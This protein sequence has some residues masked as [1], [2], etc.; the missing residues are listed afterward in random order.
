MRYLKFGIIF[1]I[2]LLSVSGQ[3]QNMQALSS[4][5]RTMQIQK[6]GEK[7]NVP[8]I[9]LGSRERLQFSFDDLQKEYR[10]Y[11]YRVEHCDSEWKKSVRIFES[12]YLRGTETQ[13]PI[14]DYKE[15]LNTTVDYTHYQFDF[16]NSR[17]GVVYSGNYRICVLDDDSR[18]E[19]CQFCFS[20][21][22]QYGQGLEQRASAGQGAAQH[23]AAGGA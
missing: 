19:V 21:V 9:E 16:P 13:I 18:K 23:A 14:E 11:I 15:S 20:V 22:D 4:D 12:D 6:D 1:I 7:Q 3:A 5:I 17:M 10:R 2:S 8:V